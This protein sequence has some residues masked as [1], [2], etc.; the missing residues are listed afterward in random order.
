[1]FLSHLPVTGTA[2]NGKAVSTYAVLYTGYTDYLID[3]EF[4]EY[5]DVKGTSE[6][7]Q[8]QLVNNVGKIVNP[9]ALS[10]ADGLGENNDVT[11]VF[12]PIV[13]NQSQRILF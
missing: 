8:S 3:C 6:F 4:P 7:S 2:D 12:V 10:S 9:F 5:L 11:E 13:L 1:M